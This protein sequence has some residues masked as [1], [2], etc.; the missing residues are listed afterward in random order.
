MKA[1]GQRM[2]LAIRKATMIIQA[3]WPCWVKSRGPGTMPWMA[4]APMN[5]ADVEFPG[6]PRERSGTMELAVT[7][8][9]AASGAAIPSGA[10]S[11][12]DFSPGLPA[13]RRRKRRAAWS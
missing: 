7:A 10:P 3:I 9:F 13:N 2:R 4:K 8:L 5:K 1:A 6:I 12:Q 11:P